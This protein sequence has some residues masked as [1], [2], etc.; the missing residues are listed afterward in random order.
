MFLHIDN[1]EGSNKAGDREEEDDGINGNEEDN[2]HGNED[3]DGILF[4]GEHGDD[5]GG[6]G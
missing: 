5:D 1:S 2:A 4:R 6:I 3:E